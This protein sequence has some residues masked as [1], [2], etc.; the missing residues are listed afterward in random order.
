MCVSACWSRFGHPEELN[1]EYGKCCA[2]CHE[3]C[4]HTPQKL[5]LERRR[6]VSQKAS[7]EEDGGEILL[8]QRN[9]KSLGG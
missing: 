8:G 2:V 3:S 9:E 7:L 5:G 6:P 4:V 1:L